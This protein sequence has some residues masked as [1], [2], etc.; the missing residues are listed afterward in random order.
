[1]PDLPSSPPNDKPKRKNHRIKA[2]LGLARRGFPVH[3]CRANSKLPLLNDWPARATTDPTTIKAWWHRWP[4]ANI[5][6]ATGG[7]Q[8]LLVIDVDPDKGGSVAMVADQDTPYGIPATVAA[9]TPR[10]GLHLWLRVP[11]G[12]PLPGNTAGKLGPGIDT[13]CARG[14]VLVPPSTVVWRAPDG[15]RHYGRY[16]WSPD[17]AD[18]IAEAPDHLLDRLD[19]GGGD[20]RAT[21][22]EEWLALVTAGV[23]DGERNQSIARLAGKL[24]RHLP[25]ADAHLAAELVACFNAAR[26]RPPLEADELQRTLD[27]IADAEARRRGR[28]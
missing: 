17:G 24:F 18:Q 5:G 8:R 4:R 13:R 25:A 22:P 27:S 11:D 3:P 19:R 26:C 23:V 1:M 9:T 21:P 10:G 7:E 28:P 14:F 15:H 20:G 16:R 6:V 12:R 2:A